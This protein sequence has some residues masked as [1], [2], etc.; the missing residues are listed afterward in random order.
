MTEQNDKDDVDV[1]ISPR[2]FMGCTPGPK[3]TRKKI[4]EEKQRKENEA[5]GEKINFGLEDVA[6]GQEF[7]GS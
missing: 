4:L 5:Q 1:Y 2:R 6:Y 3:A 7:Q